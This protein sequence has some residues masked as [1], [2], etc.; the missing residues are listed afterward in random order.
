MRLFIAI[1]FSEP[2][3]NGLTAAVRDLRPC[4]QSGNFTVR[5]NLHLTLSFLGETPPERL[6]D[7]RNAMETV[8]VPPFRLQIG[9]IGSFRREGGELYW[10]G[11]EHSDALLRLHEELGAALVR[12][13]FP[14]ER[15]E[16]RPHLTLVRRAVLRGGAQ[17][18]LS[19][20]FLEMKVEKICL[21]CSRPGEGGRIYTEMAAKALNAEKEL[22]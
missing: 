13:G 20:P 6:N 11:I 5:E 14:V 10:A 16:F 3:L 7:V 9:G 4:F 19:M 15:R 17:A 21:M 18:E 12:Q 8:T 2:V 1:L 22:S